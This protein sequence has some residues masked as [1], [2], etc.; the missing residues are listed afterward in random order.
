MND[1]PH[2]LSIEDLQLVIDQKPNGDYELS[3][4]YHMIWD[5]IE[6]KTAFGQQF[7]LAVLSSKFTGITFK[8]TN[9]ENHAVYTISHKS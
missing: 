5:D 8:E 1:W 2:P 6:N 7:K 4:I 3:E 9:Y